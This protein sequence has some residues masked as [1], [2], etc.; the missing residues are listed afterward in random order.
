MSLKNWEDISYVFFFSI[1]FYF[2]M[3]EVWNEN[4]MGSCF[5]KPGSHSVLIFTLVTFV[6]MSEF[7]SGLWSWI[8]SSFHTTS[9]GSNHSLKNAKL[10]KTNLENTFQ[11]TQY[12]LSLQNQLS[13]GSS[14]CM[15]FSVFKKRKRNLGWEK[16][17]ALLEYF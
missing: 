17:V 1:Y 10:R 3:Y 13:F 8:F 16:Q 12:I 4:K 14:Y 7:L 2:I 11:V 9:N 5:W 6:W 15:C